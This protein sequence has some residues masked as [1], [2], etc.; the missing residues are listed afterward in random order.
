MIQKIK[1]D[2][3]VNKVMNKLLKVKINCDRNKLVVMIIIN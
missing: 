2:K 1:N 3:I